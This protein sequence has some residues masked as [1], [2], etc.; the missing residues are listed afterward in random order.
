M[1]DG[2]P[3][4]LTFG[5]T[6]DAGESAPRVTVQVHSPRF[7]R[8]LLRGSVGLGESYMDGL[9]SCDDL[10]ALTRI[11]AL[12]VSALDRLRRVLAPVADPVQRWMRWLAAQHA[13]ALAPADRRPLRP[14]QRA[15]RAV[16]RPDDDVLV[17]ACFEST[18]DDACRRPRWRSSSGSAPSS[19]SRPER[20]RAGDRDAAGAASRCYAARTYGCRVTTTTISREQHALRARAGARGRPRGPRRPCCSRTTA[21]SQGTL[22][23]ARLDRDDR[24]GR[25]AVFPTRSSRRCSELLRDGRRDARCRRS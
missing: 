21:T 2:R 8:A 22:R 1:E 15:V 20:P 14:R 23:Q 18:R 7:Y 17:R 11:A 25:L 24:G 3:A 19:T 9:W 5:D 12:N 10:V 4:S 6:T 16:P 13:R